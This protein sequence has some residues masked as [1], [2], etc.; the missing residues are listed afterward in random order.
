MTVIDKRDRATMLAV[1]ALA[2]AAV[3]LPV[4]PVVV[5]IGFSLLPFYAAYSVSAVYHHAR[6]L[7]VYS[8]VVVT[9]ACFFLYS[10]GGFCAFGLFPVAAVIYGLIK[11]PP[12]P[13]RLK[14][15]FLALSGGTAGF[16]LW[17]AL[18][19]GGD[20]PTGIAEALVSWVS[21]HQSS[22]ALLLIFNRYGLAGMTPA[23][24]AA[25]STAGGAGA[26]ML[27]A[28]RR[29]LLAS[30]TTTVRLKI[31]E[32]LPAFWILYSGGG[33]LCMA[34]VP[35]IHARKRGEPALEPVSFDRWR[36]TNG[37]IRL[38]ILMAAGYAVSLVTV[39][40]IL[41]MATVMMRALCKLMLVT[42]GLSS[43]AYLLTRW[44]TFSCGM[45]PM[46]EI[47]MVLMP[48]SCK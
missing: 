36:L 21:R 17:A 34:M 48:S 41:L 23:L 40:P 15:Y 11:K 18:R 10:P 12:F 42:Q 45:G 32:I 19:F 43:M 28:V 35:V 31:P 3:S 27:P 5:W 9:S 13:V 39:R 20:I 25:Q 30:L 8:P 6:Q 37:M 26:A 44:A 1:M 4:P 7:R 33:A 16:L 14:M 46:P 2:A 29:E 24:A 22:D 38:V 47:W